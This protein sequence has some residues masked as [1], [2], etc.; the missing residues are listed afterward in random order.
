VHD[1]EKLF[2]LIF[3]LSK[4]KKMKKLTTI[5]AVVI[6]L[7][8]CKTGKQAIKVEN[9]GQAE[10][11]EVKLFTLT[12]KNGVEVKITTYGGAITSWLAPDKDGKLG[13]IVLG[14]DSL[15][16]YLR[17]T[18][19]FG[20]LIGRYGNRIANAKFTLDSV[21]YKLAANN[22][23]NNLHGGVKGFDK[24]VWDGVAVDSS[25]SLVLSYLS[26][27]GEEGFPG[28]LKVTVTYTLTDNNE[29]A[30]EYNAE[31]DKNTV[32]NLTNH[33]YFNLT[34]NTGSILNHTLQIKATKYTPVDST[35]IPTGFVP[36]VAKTP[37]DFLQPHAIGERIDSLKTTNKN[38]GYDH[39][40]IIDGSQPGTVQQCAT[41]TEPASGRV[42]EVFTEEPGLQFYSG[43]FLN[44]A[45]KDRT[46]T[47]IQQHCGLCLE[48]QHYPDSPNQLA[49]PTTT[50]KVGEKYHT[51]TVYK[52]SVLKK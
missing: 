12:N 35:L 10:G 49:F 15:A 45:I 20:A 23:K 19:Y 11:K 50:L 9:W 24:V 26:K 4:Y 16:P 22:G 43:N 1:A 13:N 6:L 46:G 2:T 31:T 21:E 52:T 44:G 25:N 30:I 41:L 36:D 7:V 42:L 8:S 33:A 18:P 27:D 3:A 38:G 17:G 39:N 5:V 28:N 37:F 29:L 32:C 48:T 34:G 14:F 47:A 40:F 51:K